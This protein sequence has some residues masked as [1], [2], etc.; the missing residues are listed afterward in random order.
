M[1][2]NEATHAQYS[3]SC[4]RYESDVTDEEWEVVAPFLGEP[5]ARGRPRTTDLREVFD[6]IQY[7]LATGC[8]WRAIPKCFLPFT[9]V[10]N[11]FYGWRDSGILG[12]MLDALRRQARELA[13]R[14]SEPTAAAIDSQSVRTTESGGPAGYDAGKKVNGR[15]RHMTVDAEGLPIEIQVHTAD[16]QDRDGA[17]DVILAMMEKAP[18]VTKLWADGGYRGPKL[19]RALAEPRMENLIEIVEK[20]KGVKEF[21]V[22]Y[23][24]WV[25]ERTFAWSGGWR[26][27]QHLEN[28]KLLIKITYDSSSK[29]PNPRQGKALRA[30]FGVRVMPSGMFGFM[31][32]TGGEEC[33]YERCLRNVAICPPTPQDD[34]GQR[35]SRT[36]HGA[37]SVVR[38]YP[39]GPKI[40]R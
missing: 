23:R 1:S 12:H 18:A 34:I 24:R 8:Q 5:S 17:P 14:A 16:V 26:G 29:P 3:R 13:G 37:R 20:P 25:V 32:S 31:D 10:Q 6:A 30:R 33:N 9:T 28:E 4:G 36:P 27:W 22:L 38:L 11:Y 15:K 7:M 40:G 21:T 2:W 35:A 19:E 39:L